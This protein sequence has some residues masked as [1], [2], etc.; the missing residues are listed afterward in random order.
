MRHEKTDLQIRGLVSSWVMADF[1]WL[2]LLGIVESGPG[3]RKVKQ[4]NKQ[5]SLEMYKLGTTLGQ[6]C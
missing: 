5:N 4:T 3:E 1:Q 6:R 2:L